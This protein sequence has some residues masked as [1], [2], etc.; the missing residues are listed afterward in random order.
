MMSHIGL[1]LGVF[2]ICCLFVLALTFIFKKASPVDASLKEYGE[3][4]YDRY[5]KAKNKQE[6]GAAIL[7]ASLFLFRGSYVGL[8]ATI[9]VA[10]FSCLGV[11]CGGWDEKVLR[12]ILLDFYKFVAG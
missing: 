5:A 2:I 10:A 1:C 11:I 3:E 6:R 4:A 7:Y 12:E 9:G 8:S